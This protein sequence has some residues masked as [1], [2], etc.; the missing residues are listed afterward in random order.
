MARNI[1]IVQ[2]SGKVG[3]LQ[4]FHKNGE[5]FVGL[6]SNISKERIKSDPA[7]ARTRENNSEF[8]GAALVSKNFRAQLIPL[9]NLTERNLHNRVTSQI[10]KMMNEG[11]GPRGKRAAQFSLHHDYFNGFELNASSKLSEIVYATIAVSANNDRNEVTLSL[12]E[13]LPSDYL[14]IPEG[15]THYKLY[16]SA[17]SISDYGPSGLLNQYGPLNAA[18]DG[19]F[20]TVSSTEMPISSANPGGFSFTVSLPGAPVLA[21]DV[22]L[23][24]ILGIAF[25]QNL[26]GTFYQLHSNNAARIVKL[27]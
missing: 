15:S 8:G 11:A 23:F 6:P 20:A 12:D 22:S 18:Q 19:L 10:R 7:F 17:L 2:I 25:L 9:R 5:S 13:F 21:A 14:N 27:F 1:G 16:A 3:G 4:F 24:S 26:N